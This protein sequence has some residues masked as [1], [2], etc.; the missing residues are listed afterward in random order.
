MRGEITNALAHCHSRNLHSIMLHDEP[1][2]R[3]RMF[4]ADTGHQLYHNYVN[5][6]DTLNLAVHPHHCDLQFVN[7]FGYAQNHRFEAHENPE[8]WYELHD[9]VSGIQESKGALLPTGRKFDLTYTR[10][11][12]MSGNPFMYAHELHTI[13]N[14][15]NRKAA[16]LVIEGREDPAYKPICYTDD[17]DIN[18]DGLYQT[19]DNRQ[20][21]QVL[22]EVYTNL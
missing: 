22:D 2:N 12:A 3:I 20:I 16:W 5:E 18:L 4:Y 14:H 1:G 9:Y 17:R 10:N 6:S 13:Y 11:E 7:L 19:M 21:I 15:P 8:G